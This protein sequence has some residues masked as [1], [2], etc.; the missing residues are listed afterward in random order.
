MKK[1]TVLCVIILSTFLFACTSELKEETELT[2]GPIQED[3]LFQEFIKN[4]IKHFG[5]L[6]NPDKALKITSH[7][8]SLEPKELEDLAKALGYIPTPKNMRILYSINKGCSDP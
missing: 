7:K 1:T 4:Q 2:V 6:K 5:Q 8:K 3:A